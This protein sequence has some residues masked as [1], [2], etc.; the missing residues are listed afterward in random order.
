MSSDAAAD[1]RDF[2]VENVAAARGIS[3]SKDSLFVDSFEVR[4]AGNPGA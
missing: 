4:E 1:E 3:G 2:E